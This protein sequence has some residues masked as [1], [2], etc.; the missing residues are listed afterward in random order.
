MSEGEDTYTWLTVAGLHSGHGI[1]YLDSDEEFELYD[2]TAPN[3]ERITIVRDLIRRLS[4]DAQMALQILMELPAKDP[5]LPYTT[6]ENHRGTDISP[7]SVRHYLG[8]YAFFNRK[9]TK[10]VL[11]ELKNLSV[12]LAL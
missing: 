1:V 6:K 12:Q 4:E 2:D 11:K 8:K 7:L 10:K 5:E 3:A 9:Q